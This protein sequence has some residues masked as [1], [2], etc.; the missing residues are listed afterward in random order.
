M[1]TFTFHTLC[2]VS[3]I[4]LSVANVYADTTPTEKP[5]VAQI[6]DTLTTLS[7]GP[8]AG[9]RANHAKGIVV[10][11]EFIAAPT[12]AA[13]TKASYLQG[14]TSTP[15][16]VRF[17]DATGVPNIPDAEGNGFPKGMAIRFNLPKEE[18]TDM[19]LISV[20]GFPAAKPEDFLGLLNSIAATKADS[21]KPSP[22]EQFLESHP[23][24]KKFGPPQNQHQ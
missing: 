4:A 24:A 19:V 11:G 21:P 20:N 22:V 23:A 14:K 3:L 5:V 18:I 8:H 1:S 16:T 9:Y 2:S 6:V 13:I 10:D 17:S 15:V 12:A 7:G